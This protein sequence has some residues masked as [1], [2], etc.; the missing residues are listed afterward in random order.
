[1]KKIILNLI[2]SYLPKLIVEFYDSTLKAQIQKWVESTDNE[3]DNQFA[4]AF[5]QFINSL[6]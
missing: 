4:L 2:L 3:L 5:D 6:R 1:M